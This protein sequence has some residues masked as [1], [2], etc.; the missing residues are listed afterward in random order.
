MLMNKFNLIS[1]NI[2]IVLK[3]VMRQ[4]G[5]LGFRGKVGGD[6]NET[7]MPCVEIF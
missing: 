7:R 2:P 5:K 6:I 1:I 4:L 3:N